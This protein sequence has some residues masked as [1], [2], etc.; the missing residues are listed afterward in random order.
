M[1][2]LSYWAGKRDG[3][4]SSAHPSTAEAVFFQEFLRAQG[5]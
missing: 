2:V 5:H 3:D 4:S 1:L